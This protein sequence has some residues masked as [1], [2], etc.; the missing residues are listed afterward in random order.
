[1]CIRTVTIWVVFRFLPVG[2]CSQILWLYWRGGYS[3][4]FPSCQTGN[5]AAFNDG[6]FVV[7]WIDARSPPPLGSFCGYEGF[8]D[9]G[10]A[11]VTALDF[12]RDPDLFIVT[13]EFH[14]YLS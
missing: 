9:P 12:D 2:A 3:A 14:S 10:I 6:C 7:V 13:F 4:L 8:I 11:D 5:E 1:M